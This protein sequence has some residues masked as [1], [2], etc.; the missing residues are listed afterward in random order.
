MTLGCTE[1]SECS[2]NIQCLTEVI[3]IC[4]LIAMAG[5]GFIDGNGGFG[6]INAWENQSFLLPFEEE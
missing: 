1:G 2:V 4:G 5:L 3:I 6:D